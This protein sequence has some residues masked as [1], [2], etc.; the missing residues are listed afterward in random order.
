[1]KGSDLPPPDPA[2]PVIHGWQQSVR[3]GERIVAI[4]LLLV[5]AAIAVG[6]VLSLAGLVALGR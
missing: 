4:M 3:T 1:M 5:L 2:E 6:A